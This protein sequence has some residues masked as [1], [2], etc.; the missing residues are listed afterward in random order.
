MQSTE[1]QVRDLDL[2]A[3][4]DI[5]CFIYIPGTDTGMNPRNEVAFI[6]C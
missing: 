5:E 6:H 1:Y 2:K 4:E 3:W